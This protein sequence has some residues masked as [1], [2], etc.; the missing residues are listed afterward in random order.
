MR[1]FIST[2][3][4]S[5]DLQGAM[6]VEALKRRAI[7]LQLEL[8]IVGIGGDRMAAAGATLIANTMAIGSMGLFESLPFVLPTLEVQRRAKQY[9]QSNPVD[10]LIL[11]D[12]LTPN[13][14][15][16]TYVKENLPNL[17]IVYYIAP[18]DWVWAPLLAQNQGLFKFTARLLM[19]NTKQLVKITNRLLAIFPEE[20]RYFQEKG[21]SATWVGHPLLDRIQEAPS[22]ELARQSLGI[23]PEQTA[24]A[25]I[26]ASRQQELKYLLPVILQA[27]RQIQEKLPSAT[28]LIPVSLDKYHSAIEEAVKK[29][30]L[31]AKILSGQTLEAI[32]ASDLAIAKSGTVNLEIALLNV[33]QV[34][35]Y[36]VNPLTIWIARQLFKFSIPFVSPPNL[37]TMKAIV[38]ELFQE[39]ATPEK[40]GRESLELLL[41]QSKRDQTLVDYQKMRSLLGE[42][43]VCDRAASQIFD[44]IIKKN[45][46]KISHYSL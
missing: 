23:K 33:P 6:L 46:T 45:A 13:I 40:I 38:P 7:E 16:G 15:I 44:F 3:E 39:Q 29:Y 25:L 1:I 14:A 4:V 9:L 30:Q 41:N 42:V 35:L 20:A 11:I 32:A 43:G 17:P 18:Q 26:P 27:A 8:E 19:Q 34:V 10:L 12:Y 24:I 37:V 21:I 31:Q 36:R 2:G 22:R 5:G 28:F